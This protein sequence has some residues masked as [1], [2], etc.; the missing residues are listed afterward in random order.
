MSDTAI[1]PRF[2]TAKEF[3]AEW[4][5]LGERARAQDQ[6]MRQI[7][8]QAQVYYDPDPWNDL[9]ETEKW[10]FLLPQGNWAS[11][12]P[13]KLPRPALPLVQPSPS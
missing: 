13:M 1:K 9:V 7:I 11:S 5:S 12:L 6:M 4:N 10:Q 2:A 8:L 3:I